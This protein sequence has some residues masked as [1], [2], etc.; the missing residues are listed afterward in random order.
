MVRTIHSVLEHLLSIWKA[1]SSIPRSA[2]VKKRS[3]KKKKNNL[4]SKY[5]KGGRKQLTETTSFGIWD[6]KQSQTLFPVLDK[7]PSCLSF[8]VV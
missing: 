2:K 7:L 6:G 8:E 4:I 3:K 5:L 1:L